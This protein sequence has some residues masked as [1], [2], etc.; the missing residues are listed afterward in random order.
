MTPFARTPIS[1][2]LSGVIFEIAYG[3]DWQVSPTPTLFDA[4]WRRTP[5][6]FPNDLWCGKTRMMGL[7]QM[8]KKL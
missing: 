7:Y 3:A 2:A 1:I 6:K 4:P 8:V 5:S